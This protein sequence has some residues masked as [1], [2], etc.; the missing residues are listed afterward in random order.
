MTT[1][2]AWGSTITCPWPTF[3]HVSPTA[4]QPTPSPPY[5][6]LVVDT[7]R[8]LLVDGLAVV[9]D[10]PGQN[11][12]GF[13]PWPGSVDE[14]MARFI[15][16]FVDRYEDRIEWEYRIWGPGSNG[17]KNNEVRV[18]PGPGRRTSRCWWPLSVAAV[19]TEE[20]GDAAHGRR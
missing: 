1:F 2:W 20:A 19:G 6:Q 7:V 10:I 4:H 12:P 15:A 11:D 9:G 8:S 18:A 17:A 14:V 16:L 5:Q 13:K 3:W